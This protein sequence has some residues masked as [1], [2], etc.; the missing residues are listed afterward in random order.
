MVNTVNQPEQNDSS[1]DSAKVPMTLTIRDV[2]FIIAAVASMVTAWGLFG[3][4]LSVVEEKIIYISNNVS[5]IR[6]IVKDLKNDD[7]DHSKGIHAELDNL[8]K[9]LRNVETSQAQ[10]KILLE[11]RRK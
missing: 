4:R 10:I 3:T 7:K 11:K 9:R 5:E 6:N 1:L 8:E 2:I